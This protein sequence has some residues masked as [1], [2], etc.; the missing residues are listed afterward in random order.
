MPRIVEFRIPMPLEASEYQVA[1][2][3]M[4][5]QA[6]EDATAD[7]AGVEVLVNE[8]YDNT[9]GHLD[10]SEYSG[11]K[12]P[13]DAGQYTLK[14]YHLESKLPDYLVAICPRTAMVLVEEAWNAYPHCLT[15]L[16]S[17]Y[18][19]T[20]K[21]SISI[22]S[23]YTSDTGT[24]ENVLGLTDKELKKREIV[25]IDISKRP[26]GMTDEEYKEEF[27]P[28]LFHSEKTGRGPLAEG[29]KDTTEPV[30]CCYKVVRASFSYWLL[31][32]K[33]ESLII[34]QQTKLFASTNQRVF[35]SI[36]DW[37]GLSM[38]D[39]REMERASAERLA[40]MAAGEDPAAAADDAGDDA[41]AGGGGAGK[42]G[43]AV[44]DEAAA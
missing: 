42:G 35:T 39:I 15:V 36:D 29:W 10:V 28:A 20:K 1:Q 8:P 4:V 31:Q 33:V 17:G 7:D 34:D 18:L 37:A 5:M 40:K 27:D 13:R 30:M 44:A 21:F 9:D 32:G 2:L 26:A 11:V 25:E 3:F 24:E 14:K 43:D 12:I 16:T 19:D 22:E 41:A 23:Q 38:E 6:S